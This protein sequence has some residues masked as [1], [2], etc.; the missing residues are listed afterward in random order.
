LFDDEKEK[1]PVKRNGRF[2]AALLDGF[3]RLLF[4]VMV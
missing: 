2:A 4:W 1:K 3:F